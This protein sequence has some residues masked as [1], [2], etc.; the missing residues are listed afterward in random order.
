MKRSQKPSKTQASEADDDAEEASEG[1]IVLYGKWQTEPLCLPR[2]VNGIV[3]RNERGHVD[4][5][6]EKCLPPGTVHLRLPRLVPVAKRLE[7]DF[8]PAMVGF[9]F[10]NGR[11]I[12]VF[13][14]IVVC[15][16]F[17]NAILEAYAE[18]E[19]RREAEEKKRNEAQAISRWYQLLSS[20]VTRQ[21]LNYSYGD[22]LT[23]QTSINM[24]NTKEKP[25]EG[26]GPVGGNEDNEK[27]RQYEEQNIVPR[28]LEVVSMITTE[29]HEHVF[30]T[31]DQDFDEESFTR[32]KRCRCGF[33]IQVEEF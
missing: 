4:V 15:A 16:E 30:L 8:A 31:D 13:D 5:W 10:R 33:S 2:A 18:E 9:D 21:R 27:S 17:R 12:P 23:S 24:E 26:V 20:I 29:D 25:S 32:T 1:N 19:E 28:K 6:S 14:G 11:S 7:I 3:P 22:R